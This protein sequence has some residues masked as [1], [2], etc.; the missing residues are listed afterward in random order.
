MASNPPVFNKGSGL[1]GLLTRGGARK[2]FEGA[3]QDFSDQQIEQGTTLFNQMGLGQQ[4]HDPRVQAVQQG[5]ANRET[6][7][8]SLAEGQ[9]LQAEFGI[10]QTPAQKI[11]AKQA[12]SSQAQFDALAPGQRALQEQAQVRGQLGIDIS[13]KQLAEM[14]KP[15]PAT[16]IDPLK[17]QP[18][19][20]PYTDR[21]EFAFLPGTQQYTVQQSQMNS[22]NS[23]AENMH[24]FQALFGQIGT[25]RFGTDELRGRMMSLRSSI[26]MDMAVS[27][28]LGV[29]S[30]GDLDLMM[31]MIPETNTL[32]AAISGEVGANNDRIAE[33]LRQVER[34]L[35]GRRMNQLS[36][37]PW[38]RI[39]WTKM[40]PNDVSPQLQ[41]YY[42][43]NQPEL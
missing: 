26:I 24:D 38:Q 41:E 43:A 23:L 20:N 30:D 29:L 22:L 31:G 11:Q 15:T 42:Q 36:L 39:D 28:E 33:Q 17:P 18:T 21:T 35:N 12:Q 2:D 10:G 9:D 5:L 34:E 16:P 4:I 6:R 32:G 27:K 25:Q 1:L 13:R 8:T 14:G 40:N 7:A 3:Q 37:N 19:F